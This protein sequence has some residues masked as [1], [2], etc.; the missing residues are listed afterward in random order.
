M[1]A[2]RRDGVHQDGRESTTTSRG[3]RMTSEK[4]PRIGNGFVEFQFS[5][6]MRQMP[7]TLSTLPRTSP[8]AASGFALTSTGTR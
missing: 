5:A 6:S 3:S 1:T 8:E 7:V 2:R 4:P